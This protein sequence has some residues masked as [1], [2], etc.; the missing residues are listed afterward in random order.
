M[1]KVLGMIGSFTLLMFVISAPVFAEDGRCTPTGTWY[2]GS[3]VPDHEG[4]KYQYTFVQSEPG[5]YFAM[6]DGAYNPDTLGA[7]VATT[8]TGELVKTSGNAYEIRLIALTTT[9]P[10]DPPNELPMVW[11]VRGNVRFDGCDRMVI[12]Y[13]WFVVYEWGKIPFVDVPA[14]WN[15]YDGEGPIVE[16]IIRMPTGTTLPRP[17]RRPSS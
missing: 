13:D 10:T 3:Y 11:A 7:A 4:Y 6:A 9:D 15:L 12:E 1:K 2:G 16:T 5:R 17:P 14:V 8:W